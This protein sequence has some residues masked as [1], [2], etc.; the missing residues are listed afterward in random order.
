M[1]EKYVKLYAMKRIVAYKGSNKPDAPVAP[2]GGS[3]PPA[4][5]PG[6]SGGGGGGGGP[7]SES[8][9]ETMD[10]FSEFD[11]NRDEETPSSNVIGDDDPASLEAGQTVTGWVGFGVNLQSCLYQDQNLRKII[12]MY[13]IQKAKAT[14]EGGA[15]IS[16]NNIKDGLALSAFRIADVTLVAVSDTSV[17]PLYGKSH[18]TTMVIS[19]VVNRDELAKYL[20][21]ATIEI[22][23]KKVKYKIKPGSFVL[24]PAK[25]VAEEV[26]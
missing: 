5:P 9:R 25:S 11:L 2:G 12:R 17:Y 10:I 1:A 13:D 19:T 4:P 26:A 20:K 14:F 3:G 7:L 15:M 6:P 22:G 23:E 8:E 18:S 21:T 16:L 24:K